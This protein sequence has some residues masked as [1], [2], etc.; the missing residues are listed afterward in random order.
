MWNERITVPIYWWF[1]INSGNPILSLF[2]FLSRWKHHISPH[3]PSFQ[4]S[5]LKRY[6]RMCFL[7]QREI[8]AWWS[9]AV[10]LTFICFWSAAVPSTW[11]STATCMPVSGLLGAIN[12]LLMNN[13][14]LPS[15]C[16]LFCYRLAAPTDSLRFPYSKPFIECNASGM[17]FQTA[18]SAYRLCLNAIS[19]CPALISKHFSKW[20]VD[21]FPA[22]RAWKCPPN[23]TV[24]IVQLC[25]QQTSL[26]L[27]ELISSERTNLSKWFLTIPGLVRHCFLISFLAKG[28]RSIPLI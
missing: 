2:A 28:S 27:G 4:L 16:M 13:F 20:K 14:H 21:W 25:H 10:S 12:E 7:G 17:L 3:T 24:L 5:I 8:Q 15:N 26:T 19:E 1:S 11:I 18:L 6:S 9:G 23:A 22:Y